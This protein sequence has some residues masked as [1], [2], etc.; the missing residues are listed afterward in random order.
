VGQ[1]E[2]DLSGRT[3]PRGRRIIDPHALVNDGT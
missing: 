2:L 1:K 3:T